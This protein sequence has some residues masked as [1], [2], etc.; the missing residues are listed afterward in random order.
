MKISFFRK[1]MLLGVFLLVSLFV[2]APHSDASSKKD[3]DNGDESNHGLQITEVEVDFIDQTL[4]I[5]GTEFD[6]DDEDDDDDLAVTLGGYGELD[7]V[8]SSGTHILASFFGKGLVEGEYL[9]LVSRGD[10]EEETDEFDLS[11]GTTGAKGPI[12]DQ[13]PQGPPG[14]KGLQGDKGLPGDPGAQGAVGGIGPDGPQGPVGL[15]GPP[16]DQGLRGDKGLPG[17]QGLPGDKG[18]VGDP[19]VANGTDPGDML[20]WGWDGTQNNWVAQ[21]HTKVPN[22]IA[23]GNML[24]WDGAQWVGS[25]HDNSKM[26]PYLAVNYIISLL[27]VFPSRSG[28]DPF[29]GEIVMFAGNFAPRNWAL[30]N[31]QILPISQHT[32]LFSLLGT[33]YGG[34]GRGTFALPDLRGRVPIHYGTGPGLSPRNIGEKGGTER[35]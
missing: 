1:A 25:P 14:D 24:V 12:G 3:D 4:F 23:P 2:F 21:Q 31:G 20:V 32:A 30:C 33:T 11:I 15:Q 34:D 22:G 8:D 7:I 35:H 10:D 29:V 28:A 6:S 27:G 17:D 19:Q 5:N 16:G 9:L 18:P 13:G 26:Q